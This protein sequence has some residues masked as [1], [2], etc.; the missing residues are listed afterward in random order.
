[1]WAEGVHL[2]QLLAPGV[3][4][5]VARHTSRIPGI[6][7][8]C[9]FPL[10][11]KPKNLIK[12]I[13]RRSSLSSSNF[14]GAE[15]DQIS[16]LKKKNCSSDKVEQV[17][18]TEKQFILNKQVMDQGHETELVTRQTWE[19]AD[20]K[21]CNQCIPN[22]GKKCSRDL[23]ERSQRFKDNGFLTRQSWAGS[24][25]WEATGEAASNTLKGFQ[26]SLKPF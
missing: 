13:T 6:I 15:W 20:V 3:S 19:A 11:A 5:D 10:E 24:F 16:F 7:L 18:T 23:A 17:I 14:L 22:K 21:K 1:M 4:L 12:K 2:L 9:L 26:F 25:Y 8:I